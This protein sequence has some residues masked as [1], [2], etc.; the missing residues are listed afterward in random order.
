MSNLRG[1]LPPGGVVPWPD[2][3]FEACDPDLP[4]RGTPPFGNHERATEI[5]WR[6]LSTRLDDPIVVEHT[7]ARTRIWV[8][9]VFYFEVDR[10]RRLLRGGIVGPDGGLKPLDFLLSPSLCLERP[11]RLL[12]SRVFAAWPKEEMIAIF[13]PNGGDKARWM[14]MGRVWPRLDEDPRFKLLA[15]SILPHE[16]AL[17]PNVFGLAESACGWLEQVR[18]SDYQLV[19]QNS[20]ALRKVECETPQLLPLLPLYLESHV[21]RLAAEPIAQLKRWFLRQGATEAAWRY[22]TATTPRHWLPIWERVEER[23]RLL[24][25]LKF[26]RVMEKAGFPPR[27][28]PMVTEAWLEALWDDCEHVPMRANWNAVDPA[29]LGLAYRAAG[30]IAFGVDPRDGDPRAV[31]RWA[32]A[33]RLVLDKNQARAGWQSLV[34]RWLGAG[35][36]MASHRIDDLTWN[37]AT[38]PIESESLRAEPLLSRAALLAESQAMRN[39][40]D[41][42]RYAVACFDG[43]AQIYAIS[44]V[45]T[46]ARLAV[47]QF[48]KRPGGGWRISEVKGPRNAAA[49]VSAWQAAEKVLAAL[50]E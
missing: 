46:G 15:G 11:L 5:V 50:G 7:L 42:P 40:L 14:V 23:H 30:D 10:E 37:A 25:T 19:W 48:S 12:A 22:L 8:L 1:F 34:A 20:S 35:G 44:D 3:P 33:T 26:L 16:M 18:A 28:N 43:K 13:A 27:P 36:K 39:C 45:Q 17:D 49:P 31:F 24:A 6:R 2:A 21:D 41:G 4:R 38:A 32:K 47:A 9:D 29:I